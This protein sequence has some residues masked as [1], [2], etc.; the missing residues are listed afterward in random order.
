M[1]KNLKKYYQVWELRQQ[2]KTFKEIGKIMGFSQSWANCI[3]NYVNFKIKYQKQ[4]RI[5]NELKNLVEKY[6]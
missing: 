3:V 4:R 5:S 2:G 1:A 6:L